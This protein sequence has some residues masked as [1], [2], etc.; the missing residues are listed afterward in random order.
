MGSAES[1]VTNSEG[2]SSDG[3]NKFSI[4]LSSK[5]QQKLH[6]GV[7]ENTPLNED[8]HNKRNNGFDSSLESKVKA[9]VNEEMS[10][11]QKLQIHYSKS[12][13]LDYHISNYEKQLEVAVKEEEERVSNIRQYTESIGKRQPSTPSRAPKCNSE[14]S[15]MLKCYK[16][17]DEKGVQ[18]TICSDMV[19]KFATCALRM[20]RDFVSR[21]V[22][23]PCMFLCITLLIL[24]HPTNY[25]NKSYS[26][27]ML[28]DADTVNV[29]FYAMTRMYSG[30]VSALIMI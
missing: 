26:V 7:D 5:L 25:I 15:S 3:G 4:G 8:G 9:R 18:S 6:R 22:S 21:G 1:K 14:R 29:V 13:E 12:D 19:E 11:R 10:R 23:Y 2:N 27:Q 30:S 16:I 24:F 17:A 28:I 20:Q